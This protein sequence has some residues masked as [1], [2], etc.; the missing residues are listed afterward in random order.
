MLL[1][2]KLE[3]RHKP[4]P[5]TLGIQPCPD[6][7]NGDLSCDRCNGSG[8]IGVPSSLPDRVAPL[9]KVRPF[10]SL[11]LAVAGLLL[12]SSATLAYFAVQPHAPSRVILTN[13]ADDVVSTPTASATI[14]EE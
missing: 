13:R 1:I 11:R 3:L 7:R 10:P 14:F 12:G 6:C 4:S 2:E 9:R 8:Q 5:L